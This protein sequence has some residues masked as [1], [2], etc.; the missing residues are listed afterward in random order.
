MDPCSA[1]NSVDLTPRAYAYHPPC[2]IPIRQYEADAHPVRTVVVIQK[3]LAISNKVL[4]IATDPLD[5]GKAP[6]NLQGTTIFMET[7]IVTEHKP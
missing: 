4:N 6:F 7:K 2:S 5:K 1:V 3:A